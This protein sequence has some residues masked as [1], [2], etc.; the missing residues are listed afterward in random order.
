MSAIHYTGSITS[1]HSL[2]SKPTNT[3]FIYYA[4]KP[5]LQ[6]N[7]FAIVIVIVSVIAWSFLGCTISLEDVIVCQITKV[8]PWSFFYMAT[9]F[10]TTSTCEAT[11]ATPEATSSQKSAITIGA[12]LGGALLLVIVL[13]V[14]VIIIAVMVVQRKK[15]AVKSFQLDILAR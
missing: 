1:L 8:I 11:S 7:Q 15:A 13:L 10:T 14:M 12:S 3:I 5:V 6:Y 4:I 9:P 2:P